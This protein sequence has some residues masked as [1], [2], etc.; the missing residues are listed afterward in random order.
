MD[1]HLIW[2]IILD[3]QPESFAK[4]LIS[5][6]SVCLLR[7]TLYQNL[8]RKMIAKYIYLKEIRASR[9]DLYSLIS[10]LF[11]KNKYLSNCFYFLNR[12]LGH[13]HNIE[14]ARIEQNA[15]DKNENVSMV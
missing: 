10:G 14:N 1:I 8:H 3:V 4:N 7:G 13:R 9:T 5:L 11:M 2:R 6:I 12:F 15:L